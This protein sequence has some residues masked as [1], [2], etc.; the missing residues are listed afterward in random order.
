RVG[1]VRRLVNASADLHHLDAATRGGDQGVGERAGVGVCELRLEAGHA[2]LEAG[3][4]RAVVGVV[5][6][7]VALPRPDQRVVVEREREVEGETVGDVLTL[8][9]WSRFGR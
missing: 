6:Y 5:L 8:R 7:G 2:E 9:A 1:R 3:R 4:G